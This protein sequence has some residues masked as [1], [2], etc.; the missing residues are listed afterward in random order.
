MT[1]ET[2]KEEPST[3]VVTEA[4]TTGVPRGNR[5]LPSVQYL[6][7][8][9][10]PDQAHLPK[11]WRDAVC[12]PAVLG[13]VFGISLLVF[14]HAPHH[15]APAREKYTIPGYSRPAF[16]DVSISDRIP[17]QHKQRILEQK[18]KLQTEL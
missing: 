16:F 7:A 13:L 15:L 3:G 9:G 2:K 14:L 17:E 12:F 10:D 6:L 1:E 4:P 18:R 11:T 8:H 5:K